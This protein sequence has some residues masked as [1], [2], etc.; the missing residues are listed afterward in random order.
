MDAGEQGDQK[1]VV[2]LEVT[3]GRLCRRPEL[4]PL[5]ST[6]FYE[7]EITDP[8]AQLPTLGQKY[9]EAQNAL[10]RYILHWD[11]ARAPAR[12]ALSTDRR[13]VWALV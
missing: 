4:L 11:P 2:L 1:S 10:V 5:Q 9:P 6:P 3:Q 12:S 8:D 7:V 13:R